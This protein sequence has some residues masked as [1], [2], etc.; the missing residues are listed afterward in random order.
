MLFGV[1]GRENT[2]FLKQGKAYESI[3]LSVAGYL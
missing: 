3:N 2:I 1:Q